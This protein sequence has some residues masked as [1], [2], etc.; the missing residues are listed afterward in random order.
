MRLLVVIILLAICMAP[1]M[2]L[3]EAKAVEY[4]KSVDKATL[5]AARDLADELLKP[6]ED[7]AA[8]LVYQAPNEIQKGAYKGL[9]KMQ[10]ELEGLSTPSTEEQKARRRDIIALFLAYEF[11]ESEARA[12]L[13]YLRSGVYSKIAKATLKA[14]AESMNKCAF[15]PTFDIDISGDFDPERL[16]LAATIARQMKATGLQMLSCGTIVLQTTLARDMTAEEIDT[17]IAFEVLGGRAKVR[18]PFGT[19]EI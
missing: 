15:H 13:S 11:S 17:E 7:T 14:V 10:R 8:P 19:T 9:E 4:E 16:K 6:D 1:V 3:R 18:H 12:V 5:D 2:D